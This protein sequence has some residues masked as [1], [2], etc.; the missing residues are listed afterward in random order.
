MK[1][2]SESFASI[3]EEQ[4]QPQPAFDALEKLVDKTIGVKLFTLM[5]IDRAKGVAIQQNEWTE[6]VQVRHETFVANTIDE[7][8]KVF[9]DHELIQSLGCESCLNLPIVIDGMV[10]GT[11]NCLHEA[12]HYTAARVAAAETLKQAGAIAFLLSAFT[13]KRT[14]NE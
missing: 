1:I 4:N 14:N 6:I 2:L 8:A 13:N 12:G 9:P 11:L 3:L 10:I 7:I 5:E